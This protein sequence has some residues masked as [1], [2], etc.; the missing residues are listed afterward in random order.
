MKQRQQQFGNKEVPNDGRDMEK[1]Q[2]ERRRSG[3]ATVGSSHPLCLPA[4]NPRKSFPESKPSIDVNSPDN[5]LLLMPRGDFECQRK[6]QSCDETM[7]EATSKNRFSL[8]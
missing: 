5:R 8:D 2:Q 3:F 6:C 7:Q 1:R 4:S